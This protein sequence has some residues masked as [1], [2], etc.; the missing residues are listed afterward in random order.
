M[1]NRR[2]FL[3]GTLVA[4]GTV[5]GTALFTAIPLEVEAFGKPLLGPVTMMGRTLTLDGFAQ[6]G[7]LVFNHKGDVIGVIDQMTVT[8]PMVDI[9]GVGASWGSYTSG[10]LRV[11]YHVVGTGPVKVRTY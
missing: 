6:A 8:R 11:E 10:L 5:A 7:E 4:A 3:T 1:M 2:S 9:T